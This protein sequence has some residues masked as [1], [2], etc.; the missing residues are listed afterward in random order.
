MTDETEIASI[1][2]EVAARIRAL[3]NHF[4]AET[5]G[6]TFKLYLPLLAK[7]PKDGVTVHRDHSYGP[8]ERHQLDV[9]E[10]ATRPA[11]PA[12]IVIFVHGG[13]FVRGHKNH[14]AAPD[15]IYGNVGTDFARRGIL[16]VNITYRLA[17][18]HQW[19]A[20]GED[21]G[22]AVK[23]TRQNAAQ[24]GGDPDKVFLFGQ[25][26]GAAHVGTY[27]FHDDLHPVGGSGLAGAILLSGLY[28]PAKSDEFTASYFGED[29]SKFAE[30]AA[31]NHLGGLDVPIFVVMAEYDPPGLEKQSV[32]LFA[33]L[34][35]RDRHCPRFTRVLGHN[36]VSTSLHLNTQDDSL[37][38]EVIDFI[39]TGR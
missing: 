23:W 31:I 4:T 11:S 10:P 3:G 9:F 25:S 38:P 13:G 37:G 20:G 30:R 14:E 39:K 32:E 36:H 29:T 17:P 26:A 8:D 28:D 24:F 22:L 19:P 2:A 35:K 1:P 12:P 34:C 33:A 16:C 27:V 21:V 18:Q 5:M 6:E 7:A 15:L